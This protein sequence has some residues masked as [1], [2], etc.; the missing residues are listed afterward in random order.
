MHLG[1]QRTLETLLS[2]LLL[3]VG[4]NWV[5]HFVGGSLGQSEFALPNGEI[6]YRFGNDAQQLGLQIA[7]ARIS[8][9]ADAGWCPA[10][11]AVLRCPACSCW[12]R[13]P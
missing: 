10:L 6:I 8:A 1:K 3:F 2:G 11:A 9:H 4:I 13:C 12:P 7:W 5:L